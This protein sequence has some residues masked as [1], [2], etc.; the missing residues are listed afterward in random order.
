MCEYRRRASWAET[1]ADVEK[2]VA[3]RGKC[4]KKKKARTLRE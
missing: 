1:R 2:K 3:E 4:R